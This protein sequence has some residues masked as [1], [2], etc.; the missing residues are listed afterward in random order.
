[1]IQTLSGLRSPHKA[2]WITLLA[3]VTLAGCGKSGDTTVPVTGRVLVNGKPAKGAAVVFHPVEPNSNVASTRPLGQ[4][5]DN[6]EFHLTTAKAGDG[7]TPGEYRVTVT[8]YAA[9]PTKQRVSEGEDS[10]ARNLLPDKYA[11]AESTPL[12]ATV[13]SEGAD[14]LNFEITVPLNRR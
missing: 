13:R 8:W 14:P 5:D 10:P 1:M 11:H 2:T 6:G 9:T 3:V 7:A 12:T 4:V